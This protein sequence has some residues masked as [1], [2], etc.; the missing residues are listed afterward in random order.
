MFRICIL[1]VLGFAT[2]ATYYNQA[3]TSGYG[4]APST[5]Y[6]MPPPAPYYPPPLVLGP[7]I[8]PE[9]PAPPE[10]LVPERSHHRPG[11]DRHRDRC[12]CRRIEDA[13][14]GSTTGECFRPEI[15]IVR[16]K[17]CM[18]IVTCGAGD[19]TLETHESAMLSSGIGISKTIRCSRRR[20]QTRDV[21]GALVDASSLRCIPPVT[22]TTSTAAPAA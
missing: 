15:T 4:A 1:A 17:D 8:L 3:P 2:H 11:K 20:W 22:T 16:G 21:T 9:L 5:S 13:C 7:I 19:Y 18:A 14:F 10:F 12:K 6:D